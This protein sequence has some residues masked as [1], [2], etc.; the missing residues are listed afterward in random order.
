MSKN[1]NFE[2]SQEN[3]DEKIFRA[4][5][6]YLTLDDVGVETNPQNVALYEFTKEQVLKIRNSGQGV[7]LPN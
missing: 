1:A 6:N 7:I 4:A 5:T 2:E 3:V